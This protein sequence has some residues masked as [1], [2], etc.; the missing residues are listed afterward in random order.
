MWGDGRASGGSVKKDSE[1]DD[2]VVYRE[3]HEKFRQADEEFRELVRKLTAYK[4]AVMNAAE[5]GVAV[6]EQMDRFFACKG[7]GPAQRE[8]ATKFLDAQSTVRAKW[9]GDIEK[10][11][12]EEVLGPVKSRVDELPKVRDYIKQRSAAKAEMQKRKKKMIQSAP[13][14]TATKREGPRLRDKHRRLQEITDRYAMFHDEVMQ[15]FNYIER[16]MGNFVT[17]PLRSLVSILSDFSTSTVS[18]LDEVERLVADAPPMTRELSPAPGVD[19]LAGTTGGVVD[20]EAWDDA[21]AFDDEDDEDDDFEIESVG[22][23]TRASGR[24]P[25]HGRVQS[26]DSVPRSGPSGA[27]AN[28]GGSSN[29]DP[30]SPT[31]PRKGRSVTSMPVNGSS[32]TF[33]TAVLQRDTPALSSVAGSSSSAGRAAAA[34]QQ[35]IGQDPFGLNSVG[36]SAAS[37][38]STDNVVSEH[39]SRAHTSLTAEPYDRR[40]ARQREGKSS[41][42]TVGS[43]ELSSRGDVLMRLVALYDFTPKEANEIELRKG[44]IIEVSTKSDSG[45]WRGRCRRTTGYFPQNYTRELTDEEEIEYLNEKR[46]RKRQGHRRQGSRDMRRSG[47]SASQP[48]LAAQ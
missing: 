32:S 45:W 43:A 46:R 36:T 34:Q 28:D 14:R 31:S 6:A 44:D 21:Y 22:T 17:G 24:R 11:F 7:E 3:K 19:R 41:G 40:A 23:A 30:S 1:D 39:G 42:D 26:A 48:S 35:H 8:L 37:S 9:V 27:A 15:R 13:N 4:A 18:S 47:R 12:D 16:N 2:E 10:R 38:A 29:H 5:S 25:P 33:P 20:Q